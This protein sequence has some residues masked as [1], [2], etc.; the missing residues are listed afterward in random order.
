MNLTLEEILAFKTLTEEHLANASREDLITLIRGEQQLREAITIRFKESL[1]RELVLK[2]EIFESQKKFC[3]LRTIMFD[4]R[5]EKARNTSYGRKNKKRK[6][7]KKPD[8]T[9]KLP[10]ERY[11]NVDIIERVVECVESPHCPC[12]GEVMNAAEMY[13]VSEALSVIPK[14]F[15]IIRY[16]KRKYHCGECKGGIVTTPSPPRIVKGS[17]YADE[18]II[19]ASINKYCD[20]VPMERYCRIASM[21]G[22]S[23]LPPNSL[24]GCTHEFADFLLPNYDATR[25]ETLESRVTQADE[26]PHRM[27]EGDSKK[28]WYLWGFSARNSCFF[29]CHDTRS[30]EVASSILAN[31]KCEVLV[32]DVYSGYRKAV[33]DANERRAIENRPTISNAYCN[34]HARRGFVDSAELG[35]RAAQFMID[36]Y[37]ECQAIEN[38]CKGKPLG[39][40]ASTRQ[41]LLPCFNEMKSFAIERLQELS[42]KSMLAKAF[43]Y[44]IDNFEGLTYF[45]GDPETPMENNQSERLLRSAVIGR[46]T[47][48][49]THSRRGAMTASIH[50]TLIESCKMVGLNPRTYY[51]E[52]VARH[53]KN[54][55]PLTPYQMKIELDQAAV[56]SE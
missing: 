18:L 4:S 11:P 2:D 19:D 28:R 51:R 34:S 9:T 50:L 21:E 1:T 36:R 8:S 45:I 53:H 10:S 3:R 5:S 6:D 14:K 40:I 26:T 30:G 42:T 49:G 29:E 55:A 37:A 24:I 32:S 35:D 25:R 39:E 48:Y 46:K 33:R 44:F 7:K 54:L 22:V 17:S 31:S 27:L 38:S 12:C 23:D 15:V 52:S 13:S 43:N 41:H 20:L 56:N 16:K 47:W